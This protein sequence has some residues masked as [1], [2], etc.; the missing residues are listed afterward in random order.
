MN[1]LYSFWVW[2]KEIFSFG[3]L[4]EIHAINI[5]RKNHEQM[6]TIQSKPTGK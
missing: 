5:E 2:L 3:N 4:S 6:E 1:G